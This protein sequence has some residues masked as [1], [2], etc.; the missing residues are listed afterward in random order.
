MSQVKLTADSGGGTTSLKAPSSTTGNAD[1]VLK[2]PV[3]DGST[4]QVLKT[5]GSGQLSF[6]SN[7]GT[8]I[9]NNAD[10]RI[11]TGSG[12][13]N[14][15]EGEANCT[16]N[17]DSL[18]LN[19]SSTTEI[20]LQYS[21]N[22]RLKIHV[23]SNFAQFL[24]QND[25]P[26]AFKTDA[27]TGSGTE[28]MRIDSSGRF[29]LNM[30]SSVTGGKFQ[31]NNQFNT[32]FA[33]TNDAT[34]CV[35]QLQKT[36]STSPDGYTIVQDGDKLGEL[37]FKGSNGSGVVIGA[38]IQAVVN[39]TPGSGND[40]PT[41]LTFRLMPDGVGSTLERM[42][43]SSSGNVG[44]GTTSPQQPL[45]LHTA[46]SSAANMVFSNTTTG[47]GASDGFV[48]GLDGAERG[49]I[50][51][52]ENT[53]LLFGTNNLERM[54]IDSSGRLLLGT[55][56]EGVSTGDTFT[57]A[58][59]SNTGMTLRSGTSNEGN[60]FF[61]DGTSGADEY[62]GSIQ[63]NHGS[64]FLTIGTDGSERMRIDSSGKVGIGNTSPQGQLHIG[65]S[66]G[67]S[68]REAIIILNNGGATGQEAGI[69]WRYEN[70]TTPRAKI[71]LDSSGQDLRFATA[72]SERMRIGSDGAINAQGVYDQTTSSGA[73]LNVASD[74]HIRRSTSSRRYKNTIT[75][76]TH[77]L[78]ELLKLKSVTF[79]GNEDGDTVF[80]G[81][82]AEDVHNAGLTEFVQ[83]DKD[84][85]PDA[86]AY[87]NMV[88]LCVKAIQELTTKVAALEAA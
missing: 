40:L 63:Y 10:N 17:G 77:G 57:I 51:N 42:R 11:I 36:R 8:T 81:L 43:I 70:I 67:T 39:G 54:R 16:F 64:N 14:T 37:Q 72:N 2:L 5:D 86:L 52:Q 83:Y 85:Q 7:A 49:Q 58:T 1:V 20:N 12:T 19:S 76:A 68:D 59:S 71:H 29:L 35:L 41:D 79:K 47:S 50:F 78:T 25:V 73:N 15:L 30:S 62:R 80:G 24:T 18:G 65:T 23:G 32:F 6:T 60:I 46:S 44:I 69:E 45:H 87:G 33:A 3:A 74:G 4:N 48:V 56:T 13:A 31:V 66:T 75:D 88:A 26:L 9:N 61:S 84:D 28:R 21:N 38:N 22:T 82:I 34:A 53:D 55:T 27:G